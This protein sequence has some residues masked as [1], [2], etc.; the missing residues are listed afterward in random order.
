MTS[1]RFPLFV[2]ESTAIGDR[3]V[4]LASMAERYESGDVSFPQAALLP[5]PFSTSE[6]PPELQVK[7]ARSRAA[8]DADNAIALHT[9]LSE[10]LPD[11]RSRRDNRLWTWLSHNVFAD[12]CRRRWVVKGNA[13][14]IQRQNN[15]RSH[16]FLRGEGRGAVGDHALA[17]LFWGVEATIDPERTDAF[18]T[19]RRGDDRYR[20][21][22]V[23][24]GNQNIHLQIRDR[25]FGA[26]P[27]ILLSSLEAL[28]QLRT[29]KA[30]MD[31]AA[32]R[33]GREINLVS[34]YRSLDSLPAENLVQL[35]RELAT[36]R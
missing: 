16:W 23:L 32:E 10:A 24:F 18:F 33:L 5:T 14:A 34:R 29:E 25:S 11:R 2:V 35:F 1:N 31:A 9:W 20:Y 27:I 13:T 6:R 8:D 21:T 12:Y 28:R 15:V 7:D 30:G 3:L 17:R 26:S 36:A 19:P 4:E 22:R